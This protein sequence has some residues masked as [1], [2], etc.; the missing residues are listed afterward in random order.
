MKL[1]HPKDH[2]TQFFG[3]ILQRTW[4]WAFVFMH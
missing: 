2:F 4:T 3:R 1:E